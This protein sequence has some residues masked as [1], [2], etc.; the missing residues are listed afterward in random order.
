MTD[1]ISVLDVLENAPYGA[2]RQIGDELV[3]IESGIRKTMDQGLTPDDMKVAQAARDAA[4][5]AID[6]FNKITA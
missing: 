1:F 4:Q 2:H 6:I 3:D 5:A